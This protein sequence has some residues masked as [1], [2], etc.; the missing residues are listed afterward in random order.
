MS[1]KVTAFVPCRKGSQR[2]PRKNIRPFHDIEH[3]LIEIKLK[4]LLRVQRID[5]ILL[6]TDDDEILNFADSLGNGRITLHKRDPSLSS[7]DTLTHQIIEHSLDVV[8]EGHVMW[9]HVT[10]PFIYGKLYS[11]ILTEYFT[12]M[13][14]GYD[15]LMTTN[16]IQ[17]FLWKDGDAL[18]YDRSVEKWP[19]TQT[20]EPVHEVN[21]GVFLAPVD[22]C[23]EHQDRIGSRPYCFPLNGVTGHDIDWPEDFAIAE[24]MLE[25]GLAKI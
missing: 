12:S 6:S 15:S 19:R 14:K 8:S 11:D 22:V 23:R 21:C 3:G 20:L 25:S 10:S 13:K 17:G 5:E 16:P 9:A 7:S 24:A 18:N 4:Q 2:T 1:D